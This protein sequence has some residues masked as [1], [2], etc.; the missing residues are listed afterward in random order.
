MPQTSTDL[1]QVSALFNECIAR[2]KQRTVENLDEAAEKWLKEA[3]AKVMKDIE[4]KYDKLS[5]AKDELDIPRWAVDPSDSLKVFTSNQPPALDAYVEPFTA[6]FQKLMA[7]CGFNAKVSSCCSL[8]GSIFYCIRISFPSAALKAEQSQ[9]TSP[10]LQRFKALPKFSAEVTLRITQDA[11]EPS[12]TDS[13]LDEPNRTGRS[14]ERAVRTKRKA[15]TG[16]AAGRLSKRLRALPEPLKLNGSP[17]P[18]SVGRRSK[19]LRG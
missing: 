16:A 19:R 13:E 9:P 12:T 8:S 2:I 3:R 5:N 14:S 1:K 7:D 10:A 11:E 4:E 6:E 15:A 18:A 17:E